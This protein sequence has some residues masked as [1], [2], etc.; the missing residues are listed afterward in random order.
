MKR[1]DNGLKTRIWM[2]AKALKNND[3]G[4]SSG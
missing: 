3:A 4:V 2:M 1:F